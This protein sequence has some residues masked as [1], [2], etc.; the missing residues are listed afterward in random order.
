MS[1]GAASRLVAGVFACGLA[2]GC[3]QPPPGAEGEV[4]SLTQVS[5]TVPAGMRAGLRASSYGISP[6]PPPTW[7][8]SSIQSMAGRFPTSQGEQVA[9]VVEVSGGGGRTKC[10]AHFPNPQ[11]G[12]VWPNVTFDATDLFAPA[13]DAFDAAGIK[14]W[15]QVEPASCDVAMLIELVMARYGARPSVVGF[16]VDVEWYR[17]DITRDGKAVT[18]AEAQDWVARTTAARAGA[19]VFLKHWLAS[20]MPPTARNGLVFVDDSQGH[21]SLDNL[22]NEFRAWGQAF[23]PAPVGFQFGYRSDKKW[24]SKLS[25]DPPTVIGNALL[26]QIPNTRDLIWVDFTATDIWPL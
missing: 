7:W 12:R 18:D 1:R 26:G 8:T 15:L 5:V 2:V 9:V 24:W 25:G 22:V 14:V 20:K 10:W 21:G 23:A 13:F 17:K 19:L 16:G 4:P 6:F 3:G 11:P